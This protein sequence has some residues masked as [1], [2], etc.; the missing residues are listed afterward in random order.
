MVKFLPGGI[1]KVE[2]LGRY[3]EAAWR[4]TSETAIRVWQ[5]AIGQAPTP[6]SNWARRWLAAC[7]IASVQAFQAFERNLALLKE[8][9]DPSR[10]VRC[11]RCQH[12]LTDPVSRALGI[13]PDCRTGRVQERRG[14]G[15]QRS[16]GAGGRR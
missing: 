12:V 2:G 15:V 7:G 14:A 5:N 10:I 3:T 11:R 8:G 9:P 4:R 16:R 1:V 13:G 6:A